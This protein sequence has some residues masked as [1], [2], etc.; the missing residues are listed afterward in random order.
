V[1]QLQARLRH[2][3]CSTDPVGKLSSPR[4]I[5]LIAD[6][7]EREPLHLPYLHSWTVTHVNKLLADY[8]ASV[9]RE[10][11]VPSGAP[12]DHIPWNTTGRA[13]GILQ[14]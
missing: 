3:T 14:Y 5:N 7:Q 12:L 9:Q 13:T 4:I 2:Q 1:A 8:Q 11:P 6:P 10:P